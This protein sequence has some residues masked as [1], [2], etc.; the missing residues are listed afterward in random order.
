MSTC[1]SDNDSVASAER[2]SSLDH[3]S[4]PL[5]SPLFR[6]MSRIPCSTVRRLCIMSKPVV[7]ILLLTVV[8]GCIHLLTMGGAIGGLL[9]LNALTAIDG[10]LPLVIVYLTVALVLVFYPVNGFL[11]DVCCGRRNIIFISLSLTLCFLIIFALPFGNFTHLDAVLWIVGSLVLVITIIGISGYGANFIQFGLDQLLE[12]PSR[13]QALFVHWA[14]WCYD[15]LSPV[16]LVIL[17]LHCCGLIKNFKEWVII[18][19]LILVTTFVLL[20][21]IIFSC[22]KRHW[23]YTESRRH[24]PYKVVAKVLNFARKNNYPLQRS[25]FTFCDDE[26]PSRLDFAKERFGGPFTTEQVEDV[27]ILLRI[28]LILLVIGPT[29]SMDPLID[30]LSFAFIGL[31]MGSFQSL[32]KCRWDMFVTNSGVIRSAITT[33]IFPAYMWFTFSLFHNRIPKMLVRIGCGMVLYFIGSLSV[34][35]VD[36]IGH[37]MNKEAN[38]TKCILRIQHI[39]KFPAIPSLNMHWSV[40]IPSAIFLGIGPTVVTATV[41]EFI[42][43]QSPISM[44]GFLFGVFFA[45]KGVFQLFGSIAI[46][47]F[48]SQRI[49][50][51]SV[52]REHSPAISCLSRSILFLSAI[53]LISLMLFLITAKRYKHRERGDRPYDQRFVVDFYTRVIENREDT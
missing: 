18:V 50:E 52:M 22:W 23:F 51:N 8:I 4:Q 45:V 6:P 7:L 38:V 46:F 37:Y 32:E 19:S 12:A 11:A 36:S 30:N 26:R 39:N 35:A 29:F 42:S 24:N 47:L 48:G 43:A 5:I 28:V 41:F 3:D 10:S 16:A 15:C 25:A 27:K 31:H 2:S 20:I 9:G 33:L 49:W 53:V 13:D 1:Y 21:L 17:G 44:K 34:L 40:M 14:K